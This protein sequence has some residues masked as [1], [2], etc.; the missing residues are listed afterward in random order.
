MQQ[1]KVIE[2]MKYAMN[3][4]VKQC[5]AMFF[6]FVCE[7]D[8]SYGNGASR[9]RKGTPGSFP[10]GLLTP[11]IPWVQLSWAFTGLWMG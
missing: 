2:W 11:T 7:W 9:V 3:W 5:Y 1:R 6:N 4:N 8:L 10:S